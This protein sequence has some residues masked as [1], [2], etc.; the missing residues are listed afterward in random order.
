MQYL[1]FKIFS[2]ERITTDTFSYMITLRMFDNYT[3]LFAFVE[4]E[5]KSQN[6]RL[7]DIYFEDLFIR[8]GIDIIKESGGFAIPVLY[9]IEF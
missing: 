6:K 1:D 8:K 5:H 2:S 4:T 3:L 9:P 7:F